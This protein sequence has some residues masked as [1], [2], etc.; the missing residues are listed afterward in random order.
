MNPS[1]LLFCEGNNSS[2]DLKILEKLFDNP[3]TIIPLGGKFGS[4]AYINGYLNAGRVQKIEYCFLLKDRDF[5]YLLPDEIKLIDAKKNNGNDGIFLYAT[6]RASMENYLIDSNL[7]ANYLDKDIVVINNVIT[8]AARSIAGYSAI[9]H[10]LG[11]I[12]RPINLSTTWTDGS[13]HLPSTEILLSF[14]EL[15]K[16]A[17]NLLLS[18]QNELNS[19]SIES[20]ELIL[21]QFINQFDEEL[22]WINQKYMIWFHGK[23]LQKAISLQLAHNKIRLESWEKYYEFAINNTNFIEKFADLQQFRQI[24]LSKI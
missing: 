2:I 16:Q 10:S 13:G 19:I 12:R 14:D 24:V 22:F 7:L 17:H 11:K 1:A 5:D 8:D 23:D 15:K 4:P 3:P 6:Y 21:N 18:Y 9:R 20:F